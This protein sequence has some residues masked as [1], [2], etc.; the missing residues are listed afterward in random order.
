[1]GVAIRARGGDSRGNGQRV[2]TMAKKRPRTPEEGGG[3]EASKRPK[4]A[5][6]NHHL[7]DLVDESQA[8]YDHLRILIPT[9]PVSS[10]E[11]LSDWEDVAPVDFEFVHEFEDIEVV[12]LARTTRV[13][14]LPSPLFT[15]SFFFTLSILGEEIFADPL[16]PVAILTKETPRTLEAPRKTLEVSQTPAIEGPR[17]SSEVL[18]TPIAEGLGMSTPTFAIL[19]TLDM[20]EP[21]ICVLNLELEEPKDPPSNLEVEELRDPP[22]NFEA[23]ESRDPPPPKKNL[24]EGE[25]RDPPL[26]LEVEGPRTS[27]PGTRVETSRIGFHPFSPSGGGLS[28]FASSSGKSSSRRRLPIWSLAEGMRGEPMEAIKAIILENFLQRN[29]SRG[30]PPERFNDVLV[31]QQIAV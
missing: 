18:L 28:G 4:H 21:R 13:T 6:V 24:E 20:K 2:K 11:D 8:C 25:P 7:R 14:L 15:G 22:P 27:T 1:M 31:H 16:A 10:E 19:R 26:N 23:G 9:T 12:P 30:V 29:V 5:N 3:D 17:M